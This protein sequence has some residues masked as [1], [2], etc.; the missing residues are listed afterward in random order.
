MDNPRLLAALANIENLEVM[1]EDVPE[2]RRANV[3]LNLRDDVRTL[4]DCRMF[5]GA[6]ALSTQIKCLCH[7]QGVVFQSFSLGETVDLVAWCLERWLRL[8]DDYP[9]CIDI[10]RGK[11]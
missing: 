1:I 11:V 7:V 4:D 10:L 8:L 9:D 6:L 3:L 2:E 5:N